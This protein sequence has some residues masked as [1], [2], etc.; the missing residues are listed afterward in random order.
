MCVFLEK[1]QKKKKTNNKNKKTQKQ[2]R[3]EKGKRRFNLQHKGDY[4]GTSG[5]EF[6]P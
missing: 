3:N 4:S 6:T 5:E 1:K 2:K